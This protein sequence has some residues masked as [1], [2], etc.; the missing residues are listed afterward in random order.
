MRTRHVRVPTAAL[1][2]TLLACCAGY[3]VMD[4]AIG[5]GRSIAV[6]PAT[7]VS[8][9][10]G[11]EV[12]LTRALRND[13]Q[14][15]LD[16]R[17]DGEAPDLVLETSLVDPTRLGRVGLRAGAFALGAVSVQVDWKLSDRNGAALA[18]GRETREFEFLTSLEER[19]RAAYDEIFQSMSEKIV[20]DVAAA[21][22]AA[23]RTGS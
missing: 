5:R 12:P 2:L 18:S 21:L 11:L 22:R 10:I 14:R 16:L 23:D 20:L 17:L 19:E 4:P 8:S 3:E 1:A 6:P 15:Q 7:N 13:L 9:W